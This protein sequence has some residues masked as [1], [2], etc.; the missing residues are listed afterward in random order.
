MAEFK[1]A[2]EKLRVSAMRADT[3]SGFMGPINNF[4][5]NLG[6]RCCK[7]DSY[8]S[9]LS[10]V[11]FVKEHFGV[12]MEKQEIVCNFSDRNGQCIGKRC[13]FSKANHQ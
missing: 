3:I 4:M 5:N 9:I 2:N 13:P 10:A 11:D 1:E 6:P 8:L 12:E 7:R